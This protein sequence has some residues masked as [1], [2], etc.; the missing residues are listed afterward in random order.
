VVGEHSGVSW[1]DPFE[2]LQQPHVQPGHPADRD[3]ALDGQAGQLV[4]E[5]DPT[6]VT[7]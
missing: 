5:L 1:L 7:Q 4:A 3:R 2:R 6:P